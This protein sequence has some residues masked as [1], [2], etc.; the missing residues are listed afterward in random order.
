MYFIVFYLIVHVFLIIKIGGATAQIGDPSGKSKDRNKQSLQVL[1][2]NIRG[3]SRS[4]QSIFNNH[5]KYLWKQKDPL[6]EP[7]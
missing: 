1:S 6:P 4:L 5:A 3:I 7:M 2:D